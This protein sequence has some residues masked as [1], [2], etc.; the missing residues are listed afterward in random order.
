M[1]TTH[2]VVKSHDKRSPSRW[3]YKQCIG[4]RLDITGLRLL[5]VVFSVLVAGCRRSAPEKPL[6]VFAAS[7]LT[8]VFLDLTTVFE[9]SHA[10][11]NVE[12]TF[13]GSQVLRTQIEQGAVADIF[14]SADETHLL[15][16][17]RAQLTSSPQVFAKN[18]LV[19][20]VPQDNPARITALADLTR[21]ST[22]VIGSASVPVGVYTRK[23][24]KDATPKFGV[25]FEQDVLS[26][27]VSEESNVRLV[28]S[29]VELG[30]VDAAIVYR[31]DATA[32]ARVKRIEI[33]PGV[34]PV[35]NY[36]VGVL[37]S[38]ES[39]QLA[40]EWSQL[41]QSA[42]GQKVFRARGFLGVTQAAR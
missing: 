4:S 18:D 24:L 31:T 35:V 32:S 20:I 12:A 5:L 23:L 3:C 21:A 37:S 14:A 17:G 33:A 15:T 11:V 25:R 10:G 19:I 28:R 36:Y 8:E 6:R 29:K 41:L 22:I 40:S 16:L 13:A 38:S 42:E 27:V 9:A 39:P 7:S 34:N 1:S 30:E 26:R 2:S